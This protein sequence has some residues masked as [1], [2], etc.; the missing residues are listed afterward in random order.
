MNSTAQELRYGLARLTASRIPERNID[1]SE[2]IHVK[3]A[4]VAPYSHE[5][6]QVIVNGLHFSRI[7][8]HRKVGQEI[9]ND[10]RRRAGSHQ[11]VG[12]APANRARFRGHFDQHRPIHDRIDGFVT[13]ANK[14]AFVVRFFT[15]SEGTQV[16]LIPR[17]GQDEG[18]NLYDAAHTSTGFKGAMSKSSDND[19]SCAVSSSSSKA[20]NSGSGALTIELLKIPRRVST[21][22]VS[23]MR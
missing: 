8:T 14:V 23:R 20:S 22:F 13:L 2:C 11:P 9:R 19:S 21:Y 12:F 16:R 5:V 7:T 15:R 3:S 6:V 18:F 10:L 17:N 1:G 4:C